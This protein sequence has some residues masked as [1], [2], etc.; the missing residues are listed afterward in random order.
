MASQV[1]YDYF[2]HNANTTYLNI[3]V[4]KSDIRYG[5]HLV[6]TFSAMYSDIHIPQDVDCFYDN[7]LCSKFMRWVASL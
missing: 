1:D 2:M 6:N 3:D 7:K 4:V 5:Q